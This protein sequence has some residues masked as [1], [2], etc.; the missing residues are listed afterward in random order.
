MIASDSEINF[1]NIKENDYFSFTIQF[2]DDF[3]V[4]ENESLINYMSIDI[5]GHTDGE[6]EIY[7]QKNSKSELNEFI[8]KLDF[9]KTIRDREIRINL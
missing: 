5:D 8:L 4:P 7:I 1:F 9:K 2:S 6:T 3:I